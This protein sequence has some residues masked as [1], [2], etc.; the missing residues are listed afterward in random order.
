MSEREV[1]IAAL[2]C[3]DPAQRRAY[4]NLVCAGDEELR[5]RV[6]RLMEAHSGVT[7]LLKEPDPFDPSTSLDSGGDTAPA[8]SSTQPVEP[9]APGAAGLL[10]HDEPLAP[11]TTVGGSDP[12]NSGGGL[13]ATGL[14]GFEILAELGRGGMGV[15]Y[16]A[17]HRQ[18]NRIVALKMIGEGKHASPEVR[19]RF[20]IEAQAVARLRHPHIIQIYD[21]GEADGHPFITLELL[22]GGSL[23]DRLEGNTQPSRTAAQLVATLATAMHAAHQ[24]GIVHRDLKPPNILF[25][26]DGT[27]K[28]TDFG[29][30][31]RLEVEEGEG[32]TQTG[33]IMGTPVY[34]APEQ[35]QG[36]TQQIGPPADIY[37]LGAI[38]Y[39][40]LTG[41]PP[42]KGASMME[43]LH[44][45][46]YDDVVPP[47]RVEP[48]IARDLETICLKCLEKESRK[49]YASA[50]D[51]A[52]D[53]TRYLKHEPIRARRTLLSERAVKW[54]RRRP[55]TAASLALGLA[56]TVALAVAWLQYDS[57]RR[58]R[59]ETQRVERL[60]VDADQALLEGQDHLKQEQW[61]DARVV[62]TNLL[63][64]I[65][66]EPRLPDRQSRALALLDQA[67]LGRA[68]QDAEAKAGERYRRFVALRQEA[69]FHETRYNGLDPSISAAV[70]R[71]IA[72][73]ALGL[74]AAPGAGGMVNW[75]LAALPSSFSDRQCAEIKEGCYELL[76]ILAEATDSPDQGLRL[77]DRAAQL[78]PTPR[79]AFFLRQ[80][81]C[82]TRRGDAPGAEDAR[83]EAQRIQPSSALDHF[84]TG[85]ERFNHFEP[86]TAR[87][88]FKATLRLQPDHFG[89]HCLTAVCC[90]QL[91]EP[92]QAIPELTACLMR[93]PDLPWLY[94]LRGFA[95]TLVATNV[96]DAARLVP[97]QPGEA[98]GEGAVRT[99]ERLQFVAAEEDFERACTLLAGRPADD[100]RYELLIY[101]GFMWFQ[102]RVLDRAAADLREAITLNDRDLRA[103]VTLAKVEQDRGQPDAA[104]QCYERAI[105]ANPD[106]APLYRGRAD[107]YLGRHD[108][109]PEQHARALSDL[110]RAIQKV[111]PGDPVVARDHTNRARLLH[112]AGRDPEALDACAAALKTASD[113]A[114]AHLLRLR[115]LL[116]LKRHADLLE[117][118]DALLTQG[119]SKASPELHELRALVRARL[120]NYA[121]AIEDDTK[122]LELRPD[123]TSLL[124]RRG[125]LYLITQAP[126]LAL[127]DFDRA[128]ELDPANSDAIL[129]RGE[130]RI[131]LGDYGL[132]VADAET[133]LGR[134]APDE[135]LTYNAARIYAQA[136]QAAAAEVRKKG[137]DAVVL[138]NKYQDR[139]LDLV[140]ET[141]RRVAPERRAEFW[142]NQIQGDPAFQVI[143]PRLRP[144]LKDLLAAGPSVP[145]PVR[146]NNVPETAALPAPIRTREA[147]R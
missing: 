83:R 20:L 78:D 93:A 39:E 144:R 120:G 4:L 115:I 16:K 42:F 139:A 37:A 64:R 123:Q 58:E 103:F 141:M 50:G 14:A 132:A 125:R 25:D 43:T 2:R 99:D 17:R 87:Q 111:G 5:Q 56:T 119:K 67:Q 117:S 46:I 76:L 75:T 77:L 101:R 109:T 22:E 31:K 41:R 131:R 48:R 105:Q 122:A 45:V 49:R 38:L 116:D 82:M 121:G 15:V 91:N 24:A 28:I 127:H 55:V 137:R 128:L 102:R 95:A 92:S 59:R 73:E 106:F 10:T 8:P 89:A 6:E 32:H 62:L 86:S 36:L 88:H 129:G 147:G 113:Y 136:A 142:R 69:L 80:A 134:G 81:T 33:Q 135:R 114:E 21:I 133:A 84:L 143:V 51:L 7:A 85:Q 65:R 146:A 26:H 112:D 68:R 110:E 61:D 71:R 90:L 29:L 118:C 138:F 11:G 57:L 1:F 96:R 63:T 13:D 53:L 145:V 44:Q 97:T 100:L 140:A 66:E 108:L 54:T 3:A 52:D 130:A 107:V 23:A 9:A 126:I 30:A 72:Q 47:S 98:E 124:T 12:S 70:T 94:V 79:R 74:F 35:A 104:I 40:M 34:M 19:K 60:R 27:P 18:L